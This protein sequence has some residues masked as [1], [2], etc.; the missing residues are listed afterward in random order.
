LFAKLMH[1]SDPGVRMRVMEAVAE[2]KGDAVPALIEALKNDDAAYWAC[3]ILRDIGPDASAAAP[4]LVGKLADK[5]GEVRR[6]AALAL[7]TIGAADTA[8]KIAG[9]LKDPAA[10]V[11][12]TY[13][14]GALGRIPPEAEP[15]MRANTKSNNKLL[16]TTSLWAL[17]RVHGNDTTLK[18][19]AIS[20]FVDQ[21]KDKD[22]YVR[23][24]AARA[25]S[26]LPPS[27][28]IT[29]PIVERALASADETTTHYM[30][31]AIAALGPQAVP[32]LTAALKH[33]ALRA[34]VANIL[35]RIGPASAPATGALAKLVND[36]DPNVGIEAAHALAN[37]GPAAKDAVPALV[38]ALK[39]PEGK[40]MHAAAYALGKIG[41]T[42]AAAEPVLLEVIRGM[43]NSRSLICAW[44]L[45]QIKGA[46]AE[47]AGK[48]V[49]EL[50]VGLGS[51]VAKSRQT[52][53]E[54]LGSLGPLAKNAREPLERAAK[55]PDAQVRA[56][57][58]KALQAVK[59]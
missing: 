17:A 29:G 15:A 43:D 13:A 21:L 33:E 2:A 59:G 39:N 46:S 8:P 37:I 30:L 38:E 1:D 19:A 9:L 27:P 24:A 10:Q 57:A 14:L 49:P 45:L 23:A 20:Q 58:E 53:A 40:R 5:R 16:S 41:P 47:T 7:A 56:A 44:A 52:A 25:L 35:G 32:R 50:L 3:L 12:A 55:D 36:P 42:A 28:E 34:Q 6:E 54:I 18:R 31:D 4:A 11:A 48:V 22:P 26:S 51:P